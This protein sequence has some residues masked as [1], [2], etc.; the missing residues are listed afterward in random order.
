MCAIRDFCY[1]PP[2]H[3]KENCDLREVIRFVENLSEKKGSE[4][5]P[6]HNFNHFTGKKKP[7]LIQ[8]RKKKDK[9][10]RG[11]Q[12]KYGEVKG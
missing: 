5:I 10:K 9:K 7:F 6:G 1:S 8:K 4:S 3:F 11:H 12:N 2:D